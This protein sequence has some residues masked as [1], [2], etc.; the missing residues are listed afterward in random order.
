[1]L[2][3]IRE[4]L[5]D[6]VENWEERRGRRF[7]CDVSREKIAEVARA[8]VETY[9]LRF[10]TASGTDTRFAV[11]ILYHFSLDE[12][13]AVLSLRVALPKAPGG[14]EG[15][16]PEEHLEVDSLAPFLKAAEWIE[17]EVREMLGVNFMGHPDPRRLLLSDDWPEGSY[18]LRRDREVQT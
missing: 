4:G 2:E 16:P 14:V 11:E 9:H 15:S 12:E 6:N 5:K 10:V 17:R 8:L 3:V 7:Y 1:M 18:P 13:G